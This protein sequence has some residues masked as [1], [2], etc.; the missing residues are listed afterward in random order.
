MNGNNNPKNVK[1]YTAEDMAAIY[2]EG[3]RDGYRASREEMF[4][5]SKTPGPESH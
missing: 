2:L 1:L 3:F 4:T 5:P